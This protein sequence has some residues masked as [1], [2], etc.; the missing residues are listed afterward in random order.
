MPGF[1]G[2]G[3]VWTAIVDCVKKQFEPFAVDVTDGEEAAEAV[4]EGGD[5]E[6]GLRVGVAL[7]AADLDGLLDDGLVALLLRLGLDGDV[8]LVLAVAIDVADPDLLGV[9]ITEVGDDSAGAES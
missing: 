3:K 6:A 7:V 8:E 9:A 4:V 2:T 1:N 5:G